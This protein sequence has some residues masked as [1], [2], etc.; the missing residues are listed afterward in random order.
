MKTRIMYI[1]RKGPSDNGPARIGRV[2]FSK[3][4]RTIY[5][6]GRQFLSTGDG[7]FGSNYIEIESD[8]VYW[9]SGCKKRGG[10]RL[11]GGTIE[12][13]DDVRVEYWTTIRCMPE[14]ASDR[15]I[16]CPG[17]YNIVK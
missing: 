14:R 8:E 10:D 5:Y 16:R 6:R 4:G 12:I 15:R 1:E 3:T 7:S 9:I 2:R 11:F 13:D 17:K